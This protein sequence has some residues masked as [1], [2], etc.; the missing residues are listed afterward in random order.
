MLLGEGS[1]PVRRVS[2]KHCATLGV[3]RW[4]RM[5]RKATQPS[6]QQLY[7]PLRNWCIGLAITAGTVL[8]SDRWLD[9]PI[10]SFV[11]QN[12]TDKTIFVWLHRLPVA[13]LLLSLLEFLWCG[14]YALTN[15][16]FSRVQSVGLAC[17]ISLVTANFINNQL[18]YA[19]GRTWPET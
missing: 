5:D 1:L 9:Q 15:R 3:S 14:F 13:F 6:S 2:S 12:V 17:S 11:H 19:F 7:S 4:L 16:P 8:A 18:K 10:A